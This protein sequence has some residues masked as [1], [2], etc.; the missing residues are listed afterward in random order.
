MPALHTT[1]CQFKPFVNATGKLINSVCLFYVNRV[2]ASAT[3]HGAKFKIHLVSAILFTGLHCYSC[4]FPLGSFRV[5]VRLKVL[6]TRLT[7]ICTLVASKLMHSFVLISVPNPR[8]QT[9]SN[10]VNAETSL[11]IDTV[12]QCVEITL[13]SIQVIHCIYVLNLLVTYDK[14][15]IYEF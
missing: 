13:A 3:E 9:R 2:N 10:D 8:V 14:I 5:R 15:I 6:L 1:E 4:C 11:S 12:P 7:C